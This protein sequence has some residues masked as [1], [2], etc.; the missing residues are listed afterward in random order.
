LSKPLLKYCGNRNYEDWCK[1]I[2]SRADYV[3]VIFAESKR[4]VKSQDVKQWIS[5]ISLP[6]SKKLVGV[7]VNAS[8]EEISNV[9]KYV[10]LDVIQCHGD[11]SPDQLVHIKRMTDLTVWKVVHHSDDSLLKMKNYAGIADA[12]LI[13]S[14]LKGVWGGTGKTF[15]W[16]F[17]P[18]Y[19]QEARKQGVPCWI[20]GGVNTENITSLLRYDLFGIDIASGIERNEK[21]DFQLIENIEKKV[22]NDDNYLP[23]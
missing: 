16:S 4:R 3:G 18:Q 13:D 15:D 1:V 7:F 19:M 21:K 11:E 20:A 12:Y 22:L 6:Q 9:L 17:I 14:K 23:R 2:R 10:P 5:Q 8:I